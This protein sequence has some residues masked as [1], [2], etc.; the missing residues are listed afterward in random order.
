MKTP[1][2]GLSRRQLQGVRANVGGTPP[3]GVQVTVGTCA[4]VRMSVGSE[5]QNVDTGRGQVKVILRPTVSRPICLGIKHPSGAYDQIFITVK[6]AADLFVWGS[7]SLTTGLVYC[8]QLLQALAC[9]AIFGPVFRGTRDHI[10]LS[11]IRDFPFRR[12]LRLAG[13]WWRHSIPPPH[14]RAGEGFNSRPVAAG[15]FRVPEFKGLR[16]WTVSISNLHLPL[17]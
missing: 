6:T 10:L 3:D 1:P 7:L 4:A 12:L 16:I 5:K 17:P 11:Q 15:S 9:A 14:G 13:L 8:L 2:D